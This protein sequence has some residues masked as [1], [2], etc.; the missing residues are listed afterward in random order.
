MPIERN[1]NILDILV[2]KQSKEKEEPE[3][4]IQRQMNIQ[5]VAHK[6]KE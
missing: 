2:Y 6:A 5:L 4:E 1:K 3:I